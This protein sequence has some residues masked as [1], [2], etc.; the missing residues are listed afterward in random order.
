ME[1]VGALGLTS[2]VHAALADD[3][4]GVTQ[5]LRKLLSELRVRA[6]EAPRATSVGAT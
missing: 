2:L 1:A 4:V 6:R 3:D 5:K